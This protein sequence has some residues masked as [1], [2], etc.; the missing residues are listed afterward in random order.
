MDIM[1]GI[2]KFHQFRLLTWTVIYWQFVHPVGGEEKGQGKEG[3]G[4]GNSILARCKFNF[5][6][7][8]QKSG[9][10]SKFIYVE[11]KSDFKIK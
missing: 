11:K 7:K 8:Y 10:R 2:E 6:R 9:V 5:I 4:G 1:T 3:G